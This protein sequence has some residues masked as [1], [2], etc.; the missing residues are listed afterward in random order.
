MKIRTV[1]ALAAAACI[2]GVS[3]LQG[4]ESTEQFIPIGKSPG[5]S[6]MYSMIGEVVSVDAQNRTVTVRNDE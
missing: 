1:R 5:M 3:A 6:G 4:Q 2:F